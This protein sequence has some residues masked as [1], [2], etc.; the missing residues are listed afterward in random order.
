MVV[1]PLPLDL[2]SPGDTLRL[3]GIVATHFNMPPS[4]IVVDT[5]ARSMG[6]GDEN[7]G[8]DIRALVDN[9]DEIRA[10]TGAH[11]TVVHH[12]GK[13]S[14]RGMRGHSSLLGSIDTAIELK[15]VKGKTSVTFTKQRD[16]PSGEN[17]WFSTEAVCI[18]VDEDGDPVTSVVARP[19]EAPARASASEGGAIAGNQ[20]R[21]ARADAE[22]LRALALL[23]SGRDF[24]AGDVVPL[25]RQAGIGSGKNDKSWTEGTRRRL[26]DMA[27]KGLLKRSDGGRFMV[28]ARGAK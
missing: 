3:L 16:H 5:L 28:V 12:A 27:D 18:G 14:E 1:L 26:G 24:A 13:D 25:F 7:N 21:Q 2:C 15:G 22:L 19:E 4:L 20:A 6:E 10:Q 23:P 17:L 11:V 8:P 9:L